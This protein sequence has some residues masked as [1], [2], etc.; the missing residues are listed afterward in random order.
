MQQQPP[1][2]GLLAFAARQAFWKIGTQQHPK[3][4]GD[5]GVE[6]AGPGVYNL[7]SALVLK[8]LPDIDEDTR[9]NGIMALR[10]LVAPPPILGEVPVD[11]LEDVLGKGDAKEVEV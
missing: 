6:P 1:P 2:E 11:V 8:L 9:A 5:Q 4:A 3:P 10:S 7:V